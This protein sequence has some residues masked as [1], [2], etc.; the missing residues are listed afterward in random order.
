MRVDASESSTTITGV[1]NFEA[2]G[3]TTLTSKTRA[4]RVATRRARVSYNQELR[5]DTTN[6][7]S[8]ATMGPANEN[9]SIQMSRRR[10]RD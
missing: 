1:D 2:S 8:I 5:V 4:R 10:L 3:H 9:L 7:M 6:E